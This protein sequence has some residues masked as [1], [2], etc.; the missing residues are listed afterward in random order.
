MQLAAKETWSPPTPMPHAMFVMIKGYHL[1]SLW[2]AEA[3]S[4]IDGCAL[5]FEYEH[6]MRKLV[7]AWQQPRR[8]A[9]KGQPRTIVGANATLNYLRTSCTCSSS[10]DKLRQCTGCQNQ[11]GSGSVC[12]AAGISLGATGEAFIQHIVQLRVLEPKIHLLVQVRSNHV[13]HAISF[14]R[15]GCGSPNHQYK[16]N[17][18]PRMYI[19]PAVLLERTRV[20]ASVQYKMVQLVEALAKGAVAYTLVYE[21]MQGDLH[22][23]IAAILRAVR[24][25]K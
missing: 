11:P 25:R 10:V 23:E 3:F 4:R 15:T 14:L 8:E 17:I 22:A 19:P 20:V 18:R 24:S 21:A 12:V 2:L 5:Y 16:T 7:P 6:C 1:G 9:T 13:K